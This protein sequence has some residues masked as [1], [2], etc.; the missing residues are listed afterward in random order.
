MF[1][2]RHFGSRYFGARYFAAT[3]ASVNLGPFVVAAVEWHAAGSVV[4]D[5]LDGRRRV[6][7]SQTHHGGAVAEQQEPQP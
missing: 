6:T 3:G 4:A 5:V 2:S 1:D 7:A